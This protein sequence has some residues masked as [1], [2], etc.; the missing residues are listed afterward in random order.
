VTL[1]NNFVTVFNAVTVDF[2][3][4]LPW[5]RPTEYQAPNADDLILIWGGSSSVGQ[6]ALQILSYY[7]YRNLIATASASHH[8]LLHSFGATKVFDYKDSDVVAQILDFTKSLGRARPAIPFVLD[9]IGSKF[10]AL[11]P[12]AKIAQKGAKVAVL[13]PVIV[14]DASDTVAPEYSMDTQAS[15]DWAEGVTVSGV[16]THFY[17]NV[18]IM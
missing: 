3:L 13:L 4:T 15:A 6:Y 2:G 14:R 18:S 11:A 16:R 7:G 10:G 1:P 12:I 9:C 5:P 8:Q 17:L